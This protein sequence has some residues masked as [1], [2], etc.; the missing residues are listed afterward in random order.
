MKL[1]GA[2]GEIMATIEREYPEAPAAVCHARVL[3]AGCSTKGTVYDYQAMALYMLCQSYNRE[4]AR[5]LEIGTYYGATAAV[6]AQA[7]PL[8]RVTTL[9]PLEWEVDAARLALREFANVQV[10][11]A[12]SQDYLSGYRGPDLDMIFVDG[13][14]KRVADDLRW[15][16]WLAVGGLMLFHDYTPE[17]APRHCP[18]V[19]MALDDFAM[20]LGREADHR[21]ID[22]Q[23]AGM[24]GWI[25]QEDDKR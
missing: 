13:D 23:R 21:I 6:M 25:K 2:P 24:L 3:T 22:D 12:T 19:V 8:A 5:I 18:P 16:G 4:D 9:N 20:R 10:I 11:C 15:W 14:H 1:I 7:A 17:G